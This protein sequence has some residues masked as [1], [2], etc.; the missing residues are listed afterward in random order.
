MN[1]Q[2]IREGIYFGA[3]MSGDEL[4]SISLVSPEEEYYVF[5]SEFNQE[6]LPHVLLNLEANLPTKNGSL[7][8]AHPNVKS[9]LDIMMEME[10]FIQRNKDRTLWGYNLAYDQVRLDKPVSNLL[11]DN[12]PHDLSTLELLLGNPE[13]PKKPDIYSAIKKARFRR[14]LGLWLADRM[15]ET[16][17]R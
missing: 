17:Q 13:F 8:C 16:V 9:R 10:L 5:S 4:I 3:V 12:D 6:Y 14:S 2:S 1:L 11:F 15:E 7:D